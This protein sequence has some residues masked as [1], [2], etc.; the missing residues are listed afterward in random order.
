MAENRQNEFVK[1]REMAI[2]SLVEVDVGGLS[3][4][5]NHILSIITQPSFEDWLGLHV[6]ANKNTS[7]AVV[8][9]VRWKH[10]FDAQ[11]FMDP[12]KGLQFGWRTIPTLERK[13]V[14]IDFHT[15]LKHL[16]FIYK[17]E[18]PESLANNAVLDGTRWTVRLPELIGE[19]VLTWVG[20]PQGF[21]PIDGWTKEIYE[22][23]LGEL[24]R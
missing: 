7:E 19:K 23:L 9:L 13:T 5:L 22:Y 15:I 18:I 1:T 16:E 4:N 14:Q 8:R 12:Y 17:V 3:E 11:R 2:T 6:L 24:N 21:Q 10:I 20:I